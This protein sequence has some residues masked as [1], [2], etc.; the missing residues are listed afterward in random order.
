MKLPPY[1]SINFGFGLSDSGSGTCIK[2]QHSKLYIRYKMKNIDT[3]P[4]IIP[5]KKT[6]HGM[7]SCA[8]F[9]KSFF[10]SISRLFGNINNVSSFGNSAIRSGS[11]PVSM[12]FPTFNSFKLF[13]SPILSSS[14]P[15][16]KLA[17][18]SRT[19]R[20]GKSSSIFAGI[21]PENLFDEMSSSITSFRFTLLRSGPD[22]YSAKK[23]P[24][25]GGFKLLQSSSNQCC[26]KIEVSLYLLRLLCETS[27]SS[28]TLHPC[29]RLTGVSISNDLIVGSLTKKSSLFKIGSQKIFIASI[30]HRTPTINHAIAEAGKRTTSP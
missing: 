2:E 1:S 23:S 18:I 30:S 3:G 19:S 10:D 7:Q 17:D 22:K 9:G 27:I 6:L 11:G 20:D 12:F 29:G 26:P 25:P 16:N 5:Q 14:G 4:Q 15:E 21:V 8:K 24:V 13:K 28:F